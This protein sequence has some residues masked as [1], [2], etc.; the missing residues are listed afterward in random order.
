MPATLT[1]ATYA[2]ACQLRRR[3]SVKFVANQFRFAVAISEKVIVLYN[4]EANES[5]HLTT[6]VISQRRRVAK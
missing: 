4:I 2:D 5:T 3:L 6:N 1:R